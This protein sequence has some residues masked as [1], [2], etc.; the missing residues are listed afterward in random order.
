MTDEDLKKVGDLF[1][2][3]LEASEKRVLGV[4]KEEIAG[5]EKRILSDIGDFVSENLV[6]QIEEKAD[7]TDIDR[8]ERKMDRILDNDIETKTRLDEIETIPVIAHELKI[9]KVY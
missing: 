5:S 7:K 8:L 2:E 1:D 3:K 9:K 6:P 4:V